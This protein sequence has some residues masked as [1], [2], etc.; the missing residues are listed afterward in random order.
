MGA[1][2]RAVI[3]GLILGLLTAVLVGPLLGGFLF[4]IEVRD[5]VTLGTVALGLLFLSL[6]AAYLPARAAVSVPPMEV[7]RQE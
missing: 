1:T 5:P 4:E 2:A 7:L 6:W 3:L